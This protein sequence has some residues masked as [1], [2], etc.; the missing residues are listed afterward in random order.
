M[1]KTPSGFSR[2]LTWNRNVGAA[3][4]SQMEL[5]ELDSVMGENDSA[6]RVREDGDF[7]GRTYSPFHVP[8]G[9]VRVVRDRAPVSGEV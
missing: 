2:C 4:H 3:K 6:G 5:F 7:S 1:I 8:C 9:S